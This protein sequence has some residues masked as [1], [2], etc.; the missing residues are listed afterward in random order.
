LGDSSSEVQLAKFIARFSP[1]IAALATAVLEKMRQILPGAI[2]L[3]YDNYNAL[4]V[5]FGPTERPSEA[6]F[7][8]AV[9]SRNVILFFFHGATL[10]DPHTLLKGSGKKSRHIVLNELE[11]LDNPA[12]RTLISQELS[13]V[14][15]WD[16]TRP[17]KI[18]IRSISQK[19]RPR[20]S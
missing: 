15:S 5:G 3:V 9:F 17:N 13:R 12:V 19:Q 4:A 18:I 11:D 7:S 16:K 1:E 2:S 20:R 14:K 6:G 8:I 10:P